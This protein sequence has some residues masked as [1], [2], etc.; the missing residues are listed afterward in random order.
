MAD[1]SVRTSSERQS[2]AERVLQRGALRDLDTEERSVVRSWAISGEEG[3]AGVIWWCL[4]IG[5]DDQAMLMMTG[6]RVEGKDVPTIDVISF[7][8]TL[9]LG[10]SSSV[11]VI[12]LRSRKSVPLFTRLKDM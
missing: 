1:S 9:P 12:S 3:D 8:R 4:P 10:A 11:S 5:E 6:R 7:L 2:H